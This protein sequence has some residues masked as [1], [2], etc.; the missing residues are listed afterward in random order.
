MGTMGKMAIASSVIAMAVLLLYFIPY[1]YSSN[2]SQ[3]TLYGNVI[4]GST[5]NPVAG[6]LVSSSFNSTTNVTNS[7]GGYQLELGSGSWNVTISESGYVP[8]T[9]TTPN[10]TTSSYKF[11]V[12]LLKPGANPADCTSKKYSVKS[13]VSSPTTIQT[14][15]SGSTPSNNNDL[16]IGGIIAII[17]IIIIVG[18]LSMRRSAIHR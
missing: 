15:T 12:F 14:G 7:T 1:S 5:C 9:L 16:I 11:D 3:F 13:T 17:I 10:V 4:D 6:A 18:Y 2:A 8:I